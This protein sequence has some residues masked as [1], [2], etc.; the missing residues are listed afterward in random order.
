VRR[1]TV[2]GRAGSPRPLLYLLMAA[3]LWGAAVSA[4]KFALRGFDPVTLLTIE[5]LAATI[6]LWVALLATGYRPPASWRVAAMLGLLEPALAYLGD[7]VGLSRTGAVDGSIISGLESGLV[8]VLAAAL[9]GEGITAVAVVAVGLGLAGLV[10]IAGQG[11]SASAIGDLYVAAGVLSASLYSIVAKRFD[12]GS[13][14]LSL[15]TWQFTSA[16][17]AALGVCVLR[18]VATGTAPSV[19]AAPQYWLAAVA[20]GAVGLAI[21][22]LL[23]NSVLSHVDASWTAI[24]LNL[25]P[26][27]GILSAIGVLGEHL[28]AASAMGSLLIGASVVYLTIF[29]VRGID[30]AAPI[31]GV[32]V[33]PESSAA[34]AS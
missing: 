9:L 7:T 22:F 8:V 34:D 16:T 12:D 3:A 1:G 28:D 2:G 4:T 21:A 27:F 18:S 25:I 17:A 29:D 31:T 20:M 11:G 32:Q 33:H 19:S 23:Y 14:P 30:G 5:L 24:V 13:D 26:V 6:T 15:T 10:V